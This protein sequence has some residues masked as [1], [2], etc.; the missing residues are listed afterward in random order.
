MWYIFWPVLPLLFLCPKAEC[1]LQ[2]PMRWVTCTRVIPCTSRL[3]METG[4]RCLTLWCTTGSNRCGTRLLFLCIFWHYAKALWEAV[5]FRDICCLSCL[6]MLELRCHGLWSVCGIGDRGWE[7]L[8][9]L[10]GF[11]CRI[12]YMH[13]LR[14][15]IWQGHLLWSF[16]HCLYHMCMIICLITGGDC[17]IL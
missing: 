5:V 1:I 15:E 11:L 12:I 2:V 13:C 10:S 16:C 9:G 17:L 3:W 6:H 14:K 7:R 4:I 8:L